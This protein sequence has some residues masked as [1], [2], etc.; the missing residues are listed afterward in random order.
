MALPSSSSSSLLSI[1]VRKK[2]VFPLV[3]MDFVVACVCVIHNARARTCVLYSH[4][5]G[6][7][8]APPFGRTFSPDPS[9]T[10]YVYN[11]LALYR[12]ARPITHR[13]ICA[14]GDFQTTLSVNRRCLRASVPGVRP[15][16]SAVHTNI[17]P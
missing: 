7:N 2:K 17:R 4:A 11:P 10:L 16:A 15:C 14:C 6:K 12:T 13:P 5:D 9:P 3:R 1:A 8:N